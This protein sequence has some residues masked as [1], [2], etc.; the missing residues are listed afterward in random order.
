VESVLGIW[1]DTQRK[2]T[3]LESIFQGSADLRSQLPEEC[4][5][6]DTV[7]TAYKDLMRNAP[8]VPLVLDAAGV[9]GRKERLEAALRSLELR[10]RALQN[11][12]ESKRRAF[13]RFYFVAPADLLDILARGAEPRAIERHLPKLFDNLHRLEWKKDEKGNKTNVAIG[14]YSGEGEYVAFEKDCECGG[15]AEVWLAKVV[16]AMKCAL[17][18]EFRAALHAYDEMPRGKWILQFSAQIAV[19]VSR[20]AFTQEVN[21]ALAQVEGG[22]DEAL[23]RVLQRQRAHLRELIALING[24][25]PKNDRKKLITMC[26]IDVHARDVVARMIETRV[27]NADAFAWQSQ[28]RYG[29][30]SRTGDPV[31]QICDAELPYQ[32]EYIGNSGCLCITPLTDRCYITLTQAQRLVLGN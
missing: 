21:D 6:F 1:T 15:P 25:L 30:D 10:E 26:T 20:I 28:L 3:A 5:E 12:L 2:W 23:K 4:I 16:D 18:A 9:P 24:P 29:R 19:L 17:R 11:Y 7:N 8:D 31:V 14:M 27:E 22:D 13:P 32:F